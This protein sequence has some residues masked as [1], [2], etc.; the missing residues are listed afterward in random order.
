[1]DEEL[2]YADATSAPFANIGNQ[3]PESNMWPV[4][5]RGYTGIITFQ[6]VSTDAQ[7]L[8]VE[9]GTIA[10]IQFA[11]HNNTYV[12]H[13]LTP[14]GVVSSYGYYA[15][16]LAQNWNG[17]LSGG[18]DTRQSVLSLGTGVWESE[19]EVTCVAS[20]RDIGTCTSSLGHAMIQ[21][22]PRHQ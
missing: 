8:G 7:S 3:T 13:F 11:P 6:G 17:Q 20:D 12:I 9:P 2:K 15:W 22:I 4:C 21:F 16:S 10:Q 1:M 19:L 14:Y 5:V 18:Q